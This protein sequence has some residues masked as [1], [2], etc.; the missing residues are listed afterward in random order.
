MKA[1]RKQVREQI[2]MTRNRVE[3]LDHDISLMKKE[4]DWDNEDEYRRL[5]MMQEELMAAEI[6]LRCLRNAMVSLRQADGE[7]VIDVHFPE[8]Y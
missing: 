4:M 6:K 7:V 8:I 3:M 2:E 1:I 5:E